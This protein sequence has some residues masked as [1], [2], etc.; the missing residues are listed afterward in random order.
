[1]EEARSAYAEYVKWLEQKMFDVSSGDVVTPNLAGGNFRSPTLDRVNRDEKLF[2]QFKH[3]QDYYHD[4]AFK[5]SI[6]HASASPFNVGSG[7]IFRPNSG[8]SLQ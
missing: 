1:M 6:G 5:R 2:H 3:R 8:T 4:L 7:N